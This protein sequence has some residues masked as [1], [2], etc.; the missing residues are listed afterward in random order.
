M[1]QV[2]H[3]YKT[4][5]EPA[6]QYRQS[7]EAILGSQYVNTS[8]SV[9]KAA[10]T[11]TF[12]TLQQVPFV[13]QPGSPEQV[14]E[15]VKL[16][17]KLGISLY[18]ISQ[19]L[20]WGYGSK[21]PCETHNVLMDLSR[22]NHI[23]VDE[24][25]AT[26]TLGPGVTQQ[27]LFDYLRSNHPSLMVSL[28]GSSPHAS[29]I[30]NALDAGYGNGQH[31]IRWDR[32]ISLEAILPSGEWVKTGFDRFPKAST[33][34][35]SQYGPGPDLKGLF[36]QSNLGIVTEMTLELPVLPEYLQVFYFSIDDESR[37]TPL[38]EVLQNLKRSGVIQGNWSLFNGY[39]ILAETSQYPWLETEGITPLDRQFMLKSLQK[40]NIPVWSGLYNGV[41]AIYSP[42]LLHARSTQL[43]IMAAI[44]DSVDRLESVTVDQTQIKR[45]RWNPHIEI[46]GITHNILKGRLLT[47]AGIQGQGSIRVGYWRKQ[48]CIPDTMHL[49]RDGCGFIWM[50]LT[51]PSSGEDALT[52]VRVLEQFFLHYGFEP[53]IVLDGIN[54]REMYVMAALVYDRE[55]P[56]QDQQALQCFERAAQE[57]RA[58]GYYQ[59]RLP[60]P[61]SSLAALGEPVDDS[62]SVFAKLQ[63]SLNP[64][65]I[66]APGRYMAGF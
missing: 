33:A 11:A 13:I 60:M 58:M 64:N 34:R 55:T 63:S 21:V 25:N 46:P 2:L 51:A 26:V 24:R 62:A 42:S 17:Q 45:L 31:V 19:G 65:H 47:F 57:L 22:L 29:I 32:V 12:D 36:R 14:Q 50:A 35:I 3:Y 59:Y 43:Y 9:T 66:L 6:S 37:L 40:Q 23:N 10:Q 44:N 15:C 53:M 39:R 18:P 27:Q 41:F 48:S 30:G 4:K 7:C 1:K 38:I 49:D 28:T 20:N 8:E 56:G 16:A 52:I 5:M 54:P 61:I